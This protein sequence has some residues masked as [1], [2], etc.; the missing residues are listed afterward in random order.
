MKSRKLTGMLVDTEKGTFE[1]VTIPN[2]LENLYGTL[3]CET[4][5]IISRRFRGIP[6]DIVCDDEGLLKPEKQKKPAIVT[7]H[8]GKV[9]EVIVGNVLIT[10]HDLEG[11]LSSLTDSDIYTLMTCGVVFANGQDGFACEI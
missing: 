3:K 5:D 4:I 10:N 7:R 6:Y 1:P 11:N 9:C 8:D 2:K